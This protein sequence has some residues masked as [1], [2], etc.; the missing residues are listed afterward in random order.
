M[1]KFSRQELQRALEIYNEKRDRSSATGDWS[2]WA[3]LFTKDADYVEHAFGEFK[4]RAAIE[5]WITGVMTPFPHMRFPQ[6]WVAYDEETGTITME[7]INLLDH[8]NDPDH[9]GF[10]FPNWTRLTYAGEGL[11]SKEEDIYNPARNANRTIK[12]WLAAGGK[13]VRK[14]NLDFKYS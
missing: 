6:S 10:G 4:G 14:P 2:I 5:R 9:E 8:P 3:S 1:P 7:V 11:L 12:A 13:F